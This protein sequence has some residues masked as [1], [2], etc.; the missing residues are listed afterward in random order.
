[1][2]QE[3]LVDIL[4]TTYNSNIDFLRKQID[5][6]L[7]QTYKNICLYISDDCS[8]EKSVVSLLKEYE[9]KDNRVR[10]FVQDKNLGFNKNFEFL[11]NKSS[12]KYIMFS[13]HDDIWHNDKVEKSLK[14]IIESDVD[15]V[16]CDETQIDS[17]GQRLH[18]SY[19]KYKNFP[20]VTGKNDILAFTRSI[21]LGCSQIITSDLKEKIL[22]F[23]DNVMAHDWLTMFMA[24]I[25]KGIGFIEEPL[26]D[27]RLHN[28]NIFGGRSLKNNLQR[29]RNGKKYSD[30]LEYRKETI[31]KAY[32]DGAK[33]C[34]SYVD[35]EKYSNIVKY[36]EAILKSKYLNFD[37]KNYF[38]FLGYKKIGKR[39]IK[40][41]MLFNFPII[42]YLVYRFA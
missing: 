21:S 31:E 26:L 16:Y 23:K 7:N 3:N 41:I 8:D 12:A 13:D 29:N 10:I 30:F 9:D 2:E 19:L 15:L 1:M 34:L 33:M 6:I 35:D 4:L 38:K 27:Y 32:L 42:S 40:E 11:L 18:D 36:Y 14:K 17:K 37:F 28:D 22:P 24:S 20:I 5:S 39:G 25:N